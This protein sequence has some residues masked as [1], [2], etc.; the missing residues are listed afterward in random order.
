[1]TTDDTLEN[2]V[3][4]SRSPIWELQRSYYSRLGVNAWQPNMVPNY[5]TTNPFI[6][7]SYARVIE[8]FLEDFAPARKSGDKREP[9]YIIEVGAGSG[10]FAYGFLKFFFSK[11]QMAMRRKRDVVYVMTDISEATIK[12]WRRHPQLKPFVNMGVLDFAY[13]DALKDHPVDLLVSKKRI[14]T[15]KLSNPLAVI[16]NYVFDSIPHDLYAAANGNLMARHVCHRIETDS[17]EIEEIVRDTDFG[18]HEASCGTDIYENE[19]WNRILEKYRKIKDGMNFSF[20]VGAMA[21]LDRLATLTK[22]PMFCL[23]GDFGATDL[24]VLQDMPPRKIARNGTYSLHVNFHAIS[25]YV[26]RRKGRFFTP[27]HAK[28]SLE[29]AGILMNPRRRQIRHLAHRFNRHIRETGPDEFFMLKKIAEENFESHSLPRI[30]ALLRLSHGDI[31]IFRGCSAALLKA[32]PG[33][34]SFERESVIA[35]LIKVD[36][37]FFRCDRTADPA[38]LILQILLGL[39]AK[40]EARHVLTRNRVFLEQTTDGTLAVADTLHRLGRAEDAV[41]VLEKLLVREPGHPEAKALMARL[42]EGR[43]CEKSA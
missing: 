15:G 26:T 41:P 11:E 18:Y 2:F 39:D 25:E 8:G 33:A 14:E 29:M 1:M 7:Q 40:K 6:A 5:V 35:E 43:M 31:K 24:S 28:S 38:T 27:G 4:L 13:L 19:D 30:L 17:T 34:N 36:D 37:I 32:L 16:A 22:G 20:P 9:H 42:S 10:R 23:A 12:Y 21:A 3:P